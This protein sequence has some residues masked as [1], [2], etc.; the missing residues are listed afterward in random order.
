MVRTHNRTPGHGVCKERGKAK[1]CPVLGKGCVAWRWV[2]LTLGVEEESSPMSPKVIALFSAD[3][4]V[5]R[6]VTSAV[7][8][9]RHGLRLATTP[10]TAVRILVHDRSEVDLFIIDLDEDV[11]G[12][13][14]LA[15]LTM[16][17]CPTPI[18]LLTSFAPGYCSRLAAATGVKAFL[19]K[20]ISEELMTKAV[21][22]LIGHPAHLPRRTLDKA[23]SKSRAEHSHRPVWL[24]GSTTANT[25]KKD[26]AVLVAPGGSIQPKRQSCGAG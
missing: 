20:P 16:L 14:L 17:S 15:A 10:E 7:T 5:R 4:A 22:R 24:S 2:Q 18:I 19:S 11:H 23:A 3:P 9:C 21:Q 13:S 8:A 6:V 25:N 12:L 26:S 1:G